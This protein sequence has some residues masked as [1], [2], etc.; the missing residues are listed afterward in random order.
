MRILQD[1]EE[2]REEEKEGQEKTRRW[3]TD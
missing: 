2:K 3:H 1:G